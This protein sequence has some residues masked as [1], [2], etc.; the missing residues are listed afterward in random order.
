MLYHLRCMLSDKISENLEK[1]EAG[2]VSAML[3]GDKSMLDEEIK[4]LY[5]SNGIGH[6]LAISGLH[7]SLIGG[8]LFELLRRLGIRMQV[9]AGIAILFLILYGQMTGLSVST[10]RAVIMTI[11]LLAGRIFLRYYDL[12]TALSV[13][14][15]IILIKQPLRIMDAGFLLS[16][17]TVLGIY[18]LVPIG[19]ELFKRYKKIEFLVL[20][21][22]YL[23]CQSFYT[24]FTSILFIAF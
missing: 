23:H 22:F 12:L 6:L 3:L 7:I 13:S 24:F 19:K 1:K 16:F 18:L 2:V 10:N 8:S 17:V 4:D 5:Q 21:Y 14:S 20:L 9:A 15:I 11:I